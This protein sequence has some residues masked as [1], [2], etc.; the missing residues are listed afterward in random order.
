[1][2][3]V[4]SPYY[5][6]S[7]WVVSLTGGGLFF[8]DILWH[9]VPYAKIYINFFELLFWIQNKIPTRKS[10]KKKKNNKK[11]IRKTHNEEEQQ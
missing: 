10:E 3:T 1:M 4:P 8:L 6:I 9:V 7:Y 5:I 2:K 11:N